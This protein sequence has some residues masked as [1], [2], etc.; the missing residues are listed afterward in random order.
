M[1]IVHSS[2]TRPEIL[3]EY[4]IL[5]GEEDRKKKTISIVILSSMVVLCYVESSN[6]WKFL[7][8]IHLQVCQGL[9]N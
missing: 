8:C 7:Q 3:N 1:Q 4:R 6:A 2:K 5:P 9:P